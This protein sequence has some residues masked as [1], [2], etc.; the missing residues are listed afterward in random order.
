MVLR[1]MVATLLVTLVAA[2]GVCFAGEDQLVLKN[3]E[4]VVGTIVGFENGMF[5]VETDFGIALVRKDKVASI[6]ISN[7]PDNASQASLPKTPAGK[8]S[9]GKARSETRAAD[10][11]A[12]LTSPART[13]PVPAPPPAK[14]PVQV[15]RPLNEPLPAHLQEHVE[16]TTYFN[17]TF[18][19]AM[20]K[21]PDW[22][23]YEGVPRETGSGI[24]AMGTENEQTLLIVDRQLWSGPPDLKTDQVMARLR[25]NYQD[26]RRLS[27]G[28]IECD[29]RPAVRRGFT[30]VLDGV[31][32]HGVAVHVLDGNTVFSIIGLTSAELFEFQQAVLNKIIKSFHFVAP[33]P[34]PSAKA[35]ASPAP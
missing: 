23:V 12:T 31:E 21:P 15:S 9:Q 26:F 25:E 4:K 30:G 11:G 20:Y 14:P 3:G 27:E 7:S 8:P 33:A 17:D 32:W 29:G 10:S 1:R 35:A 28:P 34:A 19:F 16:G 2:G 13:E 22:K 24:M 18:H 6:R 5:R